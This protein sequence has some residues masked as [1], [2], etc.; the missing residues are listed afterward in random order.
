MI[1][2]QLTISLSL[3]LL[4]VLAGLLLDDRGCLLV[5]VF[6][7][8]GRLALCDATLLRSRS[9]N[10]SGRRDTSLATSI[11][12]LL[13][14]AVVQGLHA[15]DRSALELSGGLVPVDLLCD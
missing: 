8:R 13:E 10:W 15:A 7:R 5:I 4:L 9:C 3:N 12:N 2:T 6:A 11:L 14:Q 1:E